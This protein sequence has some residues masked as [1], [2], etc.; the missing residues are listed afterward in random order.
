MT[1]SVSVSNVP[2]IAS[3]LAHTACT[4]NAFTGTRDR[5]ETAP[6]R[7]KNNPSRAI[8]NGMRE[9]ARIDECSAPMVEIAS[10]TAITERLGPSFSVMNRAMASTDPP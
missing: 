5:G 4:S 6:S 9:F 8:A 1:E 2:E 3:T 10:T 7:R